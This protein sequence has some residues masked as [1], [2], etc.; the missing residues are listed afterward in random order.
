MRKVFHPE[1]RWQRSVLVLALLVVCLPFVARAVAGEQGARIHVRWR[2]SVDEVTR[3]ALERQFRLDMLEHVEGLTWRYDLT[4]TSTENIRALVRH[5]S[6]DDTHEIERS[7]DTVAPSALRT[8]RRGR[9]A[10]GSVVV[11]AAD[12]LAMVL[13]SYAALLTLVALSYTVP[14]LQTGR[15]RLT[16]TTERIAVAVPRSAGMGQRLADTLWP[17]MAAGA[18]FLQRGVPEVDARTAGLFRIVFGVTTFAYFA[19]P[20]RHV[21]ASWLLDTFDSEVQG[22]VHLWVMDWLGTRPLVVDLITPCLLAM[23]VAFVV[24][25]FTRLTYTLFVATVLVWAYVAMSV[26][27]TH[28]HSTLVLTLV[29]LLPS[30]WGDAWSIDSWR[31]RRR[32]GAVVDDVATRRYGYT[33]WVPMLTF[34]VGFAAAAWA[35]LTV[36]TDWTSWILNGTIKYHIIKDLDSAPV[37]W[38]L[39]L[40]H[41]PFLAVLASFGA[42]TVEALAVTAAFSRNE[43]Y[44]LTIG[45]AAAALFGGIGI[46]MGIVWPGWWIPLLAF[47]PWAGWSRRFRSGTEGRTAT[48]GRGRVAAPWLSVAQFVVV[49]AVVAQ[50]I[51]VSALRLERAPMFSTYDMYATSYSSPDDFSARTPPVYNVFVV[52]ARGRMQLRCNPHE[53]FIRDFEAAVEGASEPRKRVWH[54]LRGCGANLADADYVILEGMA[55]TFDWNRLAF[56]PT[57]AV[58]RGPLG[59]RQDE[60]SAIAY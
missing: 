40:V 2:P 13:A 7:N 6:V 54:A 37:K 38:G 47:L 57:H 22:T 35:K 53:E 24:G 27:S 56:I 8:A 45:M 10:Y 59:T 14:L 31:R 44:R 55:R 46:F 48:V 51:V 36:P 16:Q 60:I 17:L 33:V 30:R 28:P 41:H 32:S 9:F 42:I 1:A 39:Q 20:S 15:V 52:G 23:C 21:D 25:V 12:W 3:H 58:T 19:S 50:Q 4:D 5:P 29:A 18:R 26:Q 49:I 43:R 11:Q 34:G